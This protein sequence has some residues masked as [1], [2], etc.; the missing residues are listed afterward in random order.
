MNSRKPLRPFNL[1][2]IFNYED[3]P[4]TKSVPNAWSE[5][6]AKD[7]TPHTTTAPTGLR[8]EMAGPKLVLE[9]LTKAKSTDV[10]TPRPRYDAEA[11]VKAYLT[12]K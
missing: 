3:A 10:I 7:G 9:D 2:G 12:S 8:P 6:R 1:N 11:I 5:Q 4:I